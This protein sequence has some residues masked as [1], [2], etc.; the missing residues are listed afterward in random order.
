MIESC[1]AG[2]VAEINN[3]QRKYV[4][5]DANGKQSITYD[6]RSIWRS[7]K[8]TKTLLKPRVTDSIISS[9]AETLSR[10]IKL[11][12]NLD[13]YSLNKIGQDPRFL[14]D[15]GFTGS[16]IASDNKISLQKTL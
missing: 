3:V 10:V 8:K 9:L 13:T 6:I 4:D 2:N 7:M 11:T 5:L 12:V 1:G 15:K 16:F 14:A